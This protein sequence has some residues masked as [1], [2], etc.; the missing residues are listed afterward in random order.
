MF[1]T[2]QCTK[3]NMAASIEK[4]E[5]NKSPQCV[6]IAKCQCKVVVVEDH[7]EVN[8]DAHLVVVQ[9]LPLVVEVQ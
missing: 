2:L 7:N 3:Q 1:G 6:N 8:N 9:I 4:C 5:L